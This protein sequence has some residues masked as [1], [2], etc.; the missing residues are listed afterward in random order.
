MS[1]QYGNKGE[2]PDAGTERRLATGLRLMDWAVGPGR[3]GSVDLV[4]IKV[5]LGDNGHMDTLVILAGLDADGTPVV[6]FHGAVPPSEAVAGAMRRFSNGTLVWKV[7]KYR[8]NG[9]EE[10]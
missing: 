6:A 1:N 5:K 4:D 7:D 2:L 8:S 10:S 3:T 9:H